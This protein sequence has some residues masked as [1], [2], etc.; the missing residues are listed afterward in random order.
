MRKVLIGAAVVAALA[1]VFHTQV[2][3]DTIDHCKTLDG[4]GESRFNPT[5]LS[6][7]QECWLDVYKADES[8]GTLG[9]I[10]WV[11]VDGEYLSMPVKKIHKAGSAEKAKQMIVDMV[12]VEMLKEQLEMER[13]TI[14]TL[15]AELDVLRPLAARLPILQADV[16][17]LEIALAAAN[18]QIATLNVDIASVRADLATAQ[19]EKADLEADLATANAART[20]LQNLVDDRDIAILDLIDLVADK[21]AEI[22]RLQ[23]IIDASSTI[24]HARDVAASEATG[25]VGYTVYLVT[26]GP[27]AGE[28]VPV[29]QMQVAVTSVLSAQTAT[30]DQEALR[31]AAEQARDAANDRNTAS[32]AIYDNL[33]N[34]IQRQLGVSFDPANPLDPNFLSWVNLRGQYVGGIITAEQFFTRIATLRVAAPINISDAQI[35]THR[36]RHYIEETDPRESADIGTTTSRYSG[37]GFSNDYTYFSVTSDVGTNDVDTTYST[38]ERIISGN[39]TLGFAQLA[40][41]RAIRIALETVVADAYKSGY[42][43]GYNDGYED[44][45]RDGFRDGANHQRGLN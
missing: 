24:A 9:S 1:G 36:G 45:Y 17:R 14:L 41:I 2:R 7:Y 4:Y 11:K 16:D 20:N 15:Q 3:A 32:I 44:G 6:E 38:V 10:L 5:E 22:D 39:N 40:D 21:Q 23:A 31:I 29:S 8:A 35:D 26:G 12:I 13:Q 43:D 19:S 42:E 28:Y 30:A 37:T 27:R 25:N 34:G 33:L 18:G